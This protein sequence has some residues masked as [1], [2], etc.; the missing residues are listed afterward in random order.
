MSNKIKKA[1]LTLLAVLVVVVTLSLQ[2]SASARADDDRAPT[3]TPAAESDRPI[4][5]GGSGC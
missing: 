4:G 3:S 2:P 5:C 1:M